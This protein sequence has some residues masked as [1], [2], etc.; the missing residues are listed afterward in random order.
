MKK[1]ISFI[2]AIISVLV[3]PLSVS[4]SQSETGH[5]RYDEENRVIVYVNA[6]GNIEENIN[7]A[8]DSHT[9][10]VKDGALSIIDGSEQGIIEI[11]GDSYYVDS[12]RAF[13]SE[14]YVFLK[15]RVIEPN[16]TALI[17]LNSRELC[18]KDGKLFSGI[19]FKT[20]FDRGIFDSQFD[21]TVSYNGDN[22]FIKNGRLANGIINSYYYIDGKIDVS[23]NGITKVGNDVYYF[24]NGK[25]TSSVVT[26]LYGKN[27]GKPVYYKNGVFSAVTGMANINS[28]GY[29]F[30]K[31]V[32]QSGKITVSGKDRYYSKSN[33]KL[34]KNETFKIK[35][36]LYIADSKGII[37][38]AP[39]V[40]IQQNTKENESI[41]YPS[42]EKPKATIASGGCGVCT[43]LMIIKNTTSNNPELVEWKQLMEKNG[44]RVRGGTDIRKTA[45]L[46]KKTYGFKYKKTK[47]IKKLKAHLKK[48]YMAICNVG[49]NGY[50]A[51]GGHYVVAAGITKSGRVIVLDPYMTPKKYYSRC[52]GVNR[53]KYFKYDKKTNE[54]T[55]TF[56]TMK[57]GSKGEYYYLFT[58]TEN[59]AL[60]KSSK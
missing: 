45:K 57:K 27:A 31:G 32:A 50:F 9:Y 14:E 29:Y 51:Y 34:V 25:L 52:K 41:P 28:D 23:K 8:D 59:I 47:S 17:E 43:S 24:E 15:E 20:Y 48:G 16:L 58:P 35:K 38:N 44:C 3:I 18:F 21:G 37:T 49:D 4:A 2:L 12:S 6:Q 55:C 26:E 10:T 11:E 46:M 53:R 54:V 42:S 36:Y 7:I 56:T 13:T 19:V 5:F 40:Y 1:L 39:L 60:R 33:F 22:Y 30:I